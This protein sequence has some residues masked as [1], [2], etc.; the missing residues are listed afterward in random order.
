MA[1][2]VA[3]PWLRL[4]G[5]VLC[6]RSVRGSSEVSSGG[7][8][9]VAFIK[10]MAF[11][12]TSAAQTQSSENMAIPAA[13]RAYI[14]GAEA[15]AGS[16]GS[17][18]NTDDGTT[19]DSSLK[20]QCPEYHR[21]FQVVND[22]SIHAK[23]ESDW[24]HCKRLVKALAVVCSAEVAATP[25]VLP[26]DDYCTFCDQERDEF[27]HAAGSTSD[28]SQIDG[29]GPPASVCVFSRAV[30]G[31]GG[32][33]S[34]GN[35]QCTWNMKQHNAAVNSGKCTAGIQRCSSAERIAKGLIRLPKT[36][37]Y[38][39]YCEDEVD[40]GADEGSR[41]ATHP[42]KYATSVCVIEAE[43]F[44]TSGDQLSSG[45]WQCMMSIDEHH[46]LMR[47][48][49][50]HMRCKGGIQMCPG[51]AAVA[52]QPAAAA[53]TKLAPLPEL[54]RAQTEMLCG[55]CSHPAADNH[56]QLSGVCVV[57]FP[58]PEGNGN[59]VSQGEVECMWSK[60]QHQARVVSGKCVQGIAQCSMNG[61]LK[62]AKAQAKK[63]LAPD[64]LQVLCD[65][66]GKPYPKAVCVAKLPTLDAN[67]DQLDSGQS[68]CLWT[69]SEVRIE[70]T[71]QL[72]PFG[73][74]TC[75]Q[76]GKSSRQ[77][78]TGQVRPIR[79]FTGSFM[80]SISHS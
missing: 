67:A 43:K 64:D 17:V 79:A 38:C 5:V 25:T 47:D 32:E 6:A 10:P 57:A 1:R 45:D 29:Q 40:Y 71:P 48:S 66:C 69:D 31:R 65:D 11:D 15:Q 62:A 63:D 12:H 74:T 2:F 46:G 76:L 42:H 53:S 56:K 4:L 21:C 34:S 33:Q 3:R 52:T 24:S 36:A 35:W 44:D 80:N 18:R 78:A 73:V 59:D 27:L 19:V 37:P 51:G 20:K 7:I 22:A 30:D 14:S 26:G 75:T 8:A 23:S 50:N 68:M 28:T 41:P 58:K 49:R 54:S 55:S 60:E 70:G 72:C 39:T 77:A 61:A 13:M 16:A 9:E